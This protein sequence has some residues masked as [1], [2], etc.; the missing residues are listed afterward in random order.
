MKEKELCGNVASFFSL[1]G[2]KEVE[3]PVGRKKLNPAERKKQNRAERKKRNRARRKKKELPHDEPCGDGEEQRV[4]A[5]YSSHSS[6]PSSSSPSASFSLNRPPTT[7][8]GG[9]AR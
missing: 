2:E 5:R 6:S 1:R 7:D 4:R 3:L 9:T 8:F